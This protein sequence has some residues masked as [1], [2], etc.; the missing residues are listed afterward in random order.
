MF[1]FGYNYDD[2]DDDDNDIDKDVSE[3]VYIV[4]TIILGL[5]YDQ[6]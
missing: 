6:Q 5:C 1:C 4:R 3:L 2:D